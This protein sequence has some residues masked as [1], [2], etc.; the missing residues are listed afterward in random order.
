MKWRRLGRLVVTVHSEQAPTEDE[1]SR[2]MGQADAYQPLEDQRI[3]VVSDGGAPNGTQRQQLIDLLHGARVATA[4]LTTSWLM[5]GS[6]AA[7]SWFNRSLR[8]FGPSALGQ[9]LEHLQLTQWERAE[10]LRLLGEFQNELDVRVIDGSTLNDPRLRGPSI[11]APAP[12]SPPTPPL[13]QSDTRSLNGKGSLPSLRIARKD[14]AA[15][16]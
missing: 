10:S 11:P 1:W 13:R 3:L 8:V 7:V 2:Y 12:S 6:G 5:R 9:A 4:I 16:R 14:G 15:R